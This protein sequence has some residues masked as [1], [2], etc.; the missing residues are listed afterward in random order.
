MKNNLFEN[1]I[2]NTPI[3]KRSTFRNS[4][5]NL[6][7][8]G[9]ESLITPRIP[10]VEINVISKMWNVVVLSV[11]VFLVMLFVIGKSFELQVIAG[12]ENLN[13]SE[14]N[15]V[16]VFNIQAE[17]GV[18]YDTE[19]RVLVRNRPTFSISM[20]KGICRD[21][22]D[23]EINTLK[24]Y[25]ELDMIR[26][27]KETSSDKNQIILALNLTKEEVLPI[28]ANLALMPSI[29]ISTIPQRDYLYKEKFAHV[30][31][32]V[33]LGDTL[34]PTI[35]GKD[36]IELSYNDYITGFPGSKVIQ[37]NSLGQ[38]IE[39]ISEKKP[40][41]GKD[42]TLYL[43]LDLQIKAMELLA[44]IVEKGEVQAGTVVAQDPNNG[45]VLIMA[46]YPTFDPD[47]LSVGISNNEYN[48]L[49][50]KSN[51]PFFNR[52]ISAA[53]PP[54]ST[55]K[56][57]MLSAAL[58][59]GIVTPETEIF[60]PGYIKIGEFIYRN[61]KL[62]GHGYVNA[63]ESLKLS[64]DI[65]FY[66]IG[67]GHDGIK[68]LGIN[69]IYEWMTKF[70]Y[71]QKTGIDLNGEISGFMPDGKYKDWYLGDDYITSI[72][73]GDVLATPMQI[74][75]N[76]AYFANGGYLL[77]PHLVKSISGE[78][79]KKP[80]IITQNIIS[81]DTLQVVREGMKMVTESG[82]TAYPFFDFAKVNGGI[83]VAGKT[84][85]SEYINSEGKE[86]THSSFTVFAPY[87]NPE[88]VLTVYLEGGGGGSTHAAPI[89]RKIMDLWYSKSNHKV[90]I[91]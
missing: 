24:K 75:N 11:A 84:G 46:S 60:D 5:S 28:E 63:R 45:G 23:S 83:V 89:A 30:L 4:G 37:V 57:S 42:I 16:R 90:S 8:I 53:Y 10:T 20:N 12:D 58:S 26:I 3:I 76:T 39:T 73:Q 38:N 77:K 1:I 74:N 22:C 55:F 48:K 86:S 29:S 61:W 15:R 40:Y 88:I 78:E 44:A 64:N 54:G 72:G 6:P 49:Q 14:G 50:S 41:P 85:T 19:G 59:E 68:G 17:R 27:N 71:G 65:Y 33:G 31:G 91:K 25:I 7:I 52:V 66:T 47:S 81:K 35:V 82:G 2:S 87:E 67:G 80:E 34:H 62:D 51:S 79:D 70:G 32:Y 43:D 9:E 18:I 13:L 69:K 36:G 21:T 56:M